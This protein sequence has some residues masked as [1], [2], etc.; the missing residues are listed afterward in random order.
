M[1]M[2]RFQDETEDTDLSFKDET[3]KDAKH[4]GHVNGPFVFSYSRP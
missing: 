2:D 1:E 4:R 3:G